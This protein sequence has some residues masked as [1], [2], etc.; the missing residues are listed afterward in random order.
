MTYLFRSVPNTFDSFASVR[1][2]FFGQKNEDP[3]MHSFDTSSIALVKHGSR[4]DRM[5]GPDGN[6]RQANEYPDHPALR[7][8]ASEVNAAIDSD[9]KH[10]NGGDALGHGVLLGGFGFWHFA[11]H[12][13]GEMLSSQD[14]EN[15]VS[16]SVRQNIG[17]LVY[18]L[19][20]NANC[21]SS[22]S[23]RPTE[24]FYGF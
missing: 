23:S 15:A 24:Q 1:N 7:L 22:G 11:N 21:G 14:R 16:D 3:G 18:R 9:E 2:A 5:H 17:P 19:V 4:P 10:E 20:G 8:S 13:S 12:F 6:E